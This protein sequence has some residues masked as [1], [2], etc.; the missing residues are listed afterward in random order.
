MLER[1]LKMKSLTIQMRIASWYLSTSLSIVALFATCSWFAM[2]ASMLH[3]TDRDLHYRLRQVV[4]FVQ[5]HYVHTEQQ[6]RGAFGKGADAPIVGVFVQ[7]TTD[8]STVVFESDVLHLHGFTS[9]GV[10]P[11]DNTVAIRTLAEPRN[12]PIRVA[13]QRI[14]VSG[15]PLTVHL[16]EPLRDTFQALREYTL[17]LCG[18]VV[19][20]LVLITSAGYFLSVKALEPVERIRKE[21]EAIDLQHLASRLPVPQTE[22]ELKRLA[23]TLNAMLARIENGFLAVQQFTADASHELRTPLALII[24]AAEVTLRRTRSRGEL[25]DTLRKVILESRRM[26]LLIEQLLAL[27][28]ADLETPLTDLSRIDISSLAHEVCREFRP[29]AEVKKLSISCT[30]PPSECTVLASEDDVRRVLFALLDNA[31]RYTERGSINVHVASTSGGVDLAVTDSGIGINSEDIVRIFDRF[32]RAD[33]VRSRGNGGA[34]LGLSLAFQ[35]VA[36]LGARI[37]VTSQPAE[38]SCFTIH[39]NN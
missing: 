27:A 21:A 35:L 38:G 26:S 31:V 18:L 14:L 36:R 10:G 13:S 5:T 33:K 29:L 4:P 15:V 28:R 6:F 34:G 37:T 32:W 7:F 9:F 20:A 11:S 24:T 16:V 8:D 30:R 3:S 1:H 2:R 17:D 39:F 12:W 23:L 19:A 25:E 22:D